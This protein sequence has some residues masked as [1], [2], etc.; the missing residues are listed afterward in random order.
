MEGKRDVLGEKMAVQSRVLFWAIAH[1]RPE[2]KQLMADV[3]E[4]VYLSEMAAYQSGIRDG[5]QFFEALS[6][7]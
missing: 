6:Q 5:I 7:E 1:R 4:L 2:D 3:E